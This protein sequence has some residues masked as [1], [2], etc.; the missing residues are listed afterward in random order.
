MRVSLIVCS[1]LSHASRICSA[2]YIPSDED[3]LWCPQ[4]EA[5]RGIMEAEINFRDFWDFR[6]LRY[7]LNSVINFAL[8]IH[9]LLSL[10]VT[11]FESWFAKKH[12]LEKYLHWMPDERHVVIHCVNISAYD[13]VWAVFNVPIY[14][15]C[16]PLLREGSIYGID[17]DTRRLSNV[18]VHWLHA[19]SHPPYEGCRVPL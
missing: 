15:S 4:E 19:H 6:D 3:I 11:L 16:N 14:H 7:S 13:T 2:E 18:K 8:L 12:M 1:I 10:Q 17:V 9:P 5:Y